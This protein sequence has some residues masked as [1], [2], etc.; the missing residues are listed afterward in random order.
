MLEGTAKGFP[1][2][3]YG[4]YTGSKTGELVITAGDDV[5]RVFFFKGRPVSVVESRTSEPL[6]RVLLE[7]GIIL[8]EHYDKSLIEMA[9][10]GRRQGEIL[11]EMGNVTAEQLEM[12][13]FAQ[14]RKKLN[15]I[16]FLKEFSYAFN[17]G[18]Q[19]IKPAGDFAS[20]PKVTTLAV[21]YHGIKN[22]M[23]E[24]E[25]D[26]TLCL[27][28]SSTFRLAGDYWS[29]SFSLPLSPEEVIIAEHMNSPATLDQLV[30]LRV[31]SRT[32]ILMLVYYLSLLDLVEFERGEGTKDDPTSPKGAS[33][34][35]TKDEHA[36]LASDLLLPDQPSQPAAPVDA[37]RPPSQEIYAAVS[38]T[39]P[40][41]A[42]DAAAMREMVERFAN[43]HQ[44]DYY[45]ILGVAKG[46]DET[47]V[48]RGYFELMRRYH[49]MNLSTDDDEI[50]HV[51]KILKVK[52]NEAYTT[53]ASPNLRDEYDRA[54][55]EAAGRDGQAGQRAG[56]AELEYHKGDF[57]LGKGDFRNALASFKRALE[58]YGQQPDFVAAYGWALYSD[59]DQAEDV[60]RPMG[61]QYL[62]KAVVLNPNC[63]RAFIH[64]AS[65]ARLEGK[66]DEAE[67]Y[68]VEAVKL[69]A[70]H[71][72]I[73]PERDAIAD[74]RKKPGAAP[75]ATQA[76]I[77]KKGFFSKILGGSD[78]E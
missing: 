2:I 5:R 58:L 11:I 59:P 70:A 38:P 49:P 53:L 34:A 64:M 65:V 40:S 44:M 76:R 36:V 7:M 75:K 48:R 41:P 46:A 1:G 17:E 14:L 43:I 23:K 55:S 32:E 21:I 68:L 28:G 63:A 62:R 73:G 8:Q 10:T 22:S 50:V 18:E 20:S 4:I 12:A 9:K 33:G 26:G 37:A 57:F 39:P 61:R 13:L 47:A 6:G 42:E 35:G 60:R 19:Y 29:M 15:R 74:A 67:K 66:I 72:L 77:E 16:F 52:A 3:L 71:E 56:D 45:Q 78:D 31:L 24:T 30:G 54:V 25:L 27:D 51:A 69:D